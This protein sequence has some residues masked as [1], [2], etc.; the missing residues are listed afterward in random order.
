MD[1]KDLINRIRGIGFMAGVLERQSHEPLCSKCISYAI[2]LEE[3]LDALK[4]LKESHSPGSVPSEFKTVLLE[5]DR[6]IMTLEV[7][8]DPEKQRKAG[9][10]H[11]PDK[12]CFVKKARML[13]LFFKEKK[14][15]N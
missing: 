6:I 8:S 3:S 9:R 10:C 12:A 13:F 7:P 1:E 4:E 11:L 5:A 15:I 14:S 2:T